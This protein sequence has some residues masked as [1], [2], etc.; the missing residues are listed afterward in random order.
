MNSV[1]CYI[2]NNPSGIDMW[3][4]GSSNKV[5]SLRLAAVWMTGVALYAGDFLFKRIPL[6]REPISVEIVVD[7]WIPFV[8]ETAWLYLIGWLVFLFGIAGWVIWEN[9]DDWITVRKLLFAAIIMQVGAW[10]LQF[11]VPTYF[12]RPE[13]PGTGGAYWLINRIYETDPPTH[14][15]PSLHIASIAVVTWFFA[16]NGDFRR[17]VVRWILIAI[18]SVSVVTTKQHGIID[19][20]AGIAWAYAACHAGYY[21]S[22]KWDRIWGL[23]PSA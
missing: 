18:V 6:P 20:P 13:L 15:L 12:P 11:A 3:E 21:L 22:V 14:V 7:R 17:R 5:N 4:S 9:R 8:P 23:A 2:D 1:P 10:L 19:V 16:L